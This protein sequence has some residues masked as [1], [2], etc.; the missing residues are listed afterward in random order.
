MKTRIT[1]ELDIEADETGFAAFQVRELLR[2]IHQVE[3][4]W[5]K[6]LGESSAFLNN[7]VRFETSSSSFE[8]WQTG[9]PLRFA[10]ET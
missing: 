2:R 10:D 4:D 1:V 8:V 5:E 6:E 3:Q 9:Q 7:A